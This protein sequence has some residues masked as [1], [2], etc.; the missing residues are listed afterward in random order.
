MEFKELSKE[1]QM[2]IFGG[3]EATDGFWYIVGLVLR[4]LHE[5]G[6]AAQKDGGYAKNKC[7]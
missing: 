4:A 5:M 7:P 1:E 2:S 3:N 6:T